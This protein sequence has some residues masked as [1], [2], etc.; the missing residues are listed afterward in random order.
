MRYLYQ[1]LSLAPAPVFFAGFLYSVSNPPALCT[2]FPYE[3]PVMW[4]VMS[5]AHA[6]PWLLFYQQNFARD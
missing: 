5:L 3:M 6:V 4:L 1:V 2:S